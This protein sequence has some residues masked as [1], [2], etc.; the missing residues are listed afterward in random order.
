MATLQEDEIV[1]TEMIVVANVQALRAPPPFAPAD[2]KNPTRAEVLAAQ[3]IM[4]VHQRK[5]R[6]KRS[7]K[8]NKRSL[9]IR[10]VSRRDLIPGE[11]EWRHDF[12]A[13]Y[14]E[15]VR[16]PAAI[17]LTPKRLIARCEKIA[18]EYGK[19]QTRRCPKGVERF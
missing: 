12:D 6:A 14:H 10:E 5:R 3:K 1:S 18:D 9:R 15:L 8:R 11:R 2:A 17:R 7:K 4:T 13:I 16:N 19:M